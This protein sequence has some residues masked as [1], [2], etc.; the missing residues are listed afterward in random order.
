MTQFSKHMHI[1]T[2]NFSNGGNGD[3][4]NSFKIDKV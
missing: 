4:L 3:N 2:K 1:F